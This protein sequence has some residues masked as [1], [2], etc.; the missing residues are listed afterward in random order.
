MALGFVLQVQHLLR[1]LIH[2]ERIFITELESEGEQNTSISWADI[3]DE[4]EAAA[5][6]SLNSFNV[7]TGG[8]K[9]EH[10]AATQS[11]EA[12]SGP[13][14]T[15]GLIPLT[16]A[17]ARAINKNENRGKKTMP[18]LFIVAL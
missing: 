18:C 15:G 2:L 12:P 7:G 9:M 11:Q 5:K 3:V 1:F 4:E 10:T 13:R 17:V 8:P 14:H 6:I 16:P